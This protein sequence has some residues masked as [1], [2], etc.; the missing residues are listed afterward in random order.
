MQ[1]LNIWQRL[2]LI[3]AALCAV[4]VAISAA[5]IMIL[6]DTVL[7][8]RR[9]DVRQLVDAAVKIFTGYDEKSR[10]G[11]MPAEEAKRLAFEAIGAMR[12]GAFADYV[13]VYG[14]GTANA[15][16]TYVHANPKYINVNRW[17][18]TDSHGR[19]LI[20]DVVGVA[21]AGGGFLGYLSPRAS[22]G[23]ELPKLSYIAAVGNG[24]GL[25]AVQAGLYIDDIDDV[26]WRQT[27]RVAA[28]GVVG[29]LIAGAIAFGLGRG[30]TRPLER[31][32][33]TMD[34]LARGN[35]DVTVPFLKLRNEIGDMARSL[36]VFRD[37]MTKE[38]ELA[39]EQAA[40]HQHAAAEKHTALVEMA[41]R[42][43]V[44]AS[45]ALT[46]VSARTSTMAATAEEMHASASRTGVSA[47]TASAA[48]GQALANAQM[49]ASAAEQ[50]ASSIQEIGGQVGRSSTVVARAVEAGVET[51]KTI[52]TLN[53]QVGRIGAVADMI[54]E[55]A[56]KTNLLALNATI[57]AARAGEAGRGFAVV[58]SEVKALATQTA[59][60]TQ[61]IARHISEVRAATGAAVAA[62]D[63][64]ERT[65]T[66]IDTIS[67]SIAAAVEQQGAATAEIARNVT[68]TAAAANEMT[69]RVADVSAEAV[70]TGNHAVEVRDN[71]A[72]LITA[73]ED[74]KQS[75]I[76]V[77][78]GATTEVDRGAGARRAA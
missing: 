28:A 67:G 52:E 48:A 34:F 38:N 2:S 14:A 6:R 72:A 47:E 53:Q 26:V 44:E 3:I 31:I 10:S 78:R 75:V 9:T 11:A 21:R 33:G 22:G 68:E 62:V 12:W 45:A 57:E 30:L 76:R 54:G 74:L 66:E 23:A 19:L 35:L 61:E 69:G 65:I 29:L 46:S 60:S 43:E 56:A 39:A 13:G 64:I 37:H 20:Q 70:K 24:E 63:Q 18:F 27:V 32:R 49:V 25:L 36:L 5:Q 8:E 50:L 59:G 15:G 77:V 55:I 42:I 73:M 16:I 4:F 71:T 7:E 51:R 58:A 41:D 1:N 40:E 17:G